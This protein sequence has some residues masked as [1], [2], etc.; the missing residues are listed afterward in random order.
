MKREL[1]VQ[2]NNPIGIKW[3][4]AKPGSNSLQVV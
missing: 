1:N 2:Q 3:D 4:G